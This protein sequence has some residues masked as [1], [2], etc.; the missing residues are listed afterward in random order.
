VLLGLGVAQLV[1]A[2]TAWAARV[3][4]GA[5]ILALSSAL[6]IGVG[7]GVV[8]AWRAAGVDPVVG[9]RAEK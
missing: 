3:S 5:L 7:F 8:P 1:S 6:A 2:M 9:L 4:A